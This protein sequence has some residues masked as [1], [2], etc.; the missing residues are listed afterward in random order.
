MAARMDAI[1]NVV[2][3]YEGDRPKLPALLLGS[4]YDTVCNAGKWEGPLGVVTAI[5]CVADLRRRGKRLPFAIEVIGFA[6][7]EGARFNSTLLGSRAVAGTFNEAVLSSR[8]RNGITMQ[9]ALQNF[10]LDPR[11]I[12][13]AARAGRVCRLSRT[14]H[15]AGS[16]AGG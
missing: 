15:R 13:D 16:D 9:E 5:A 12:G 3:R 11:H 4:H 14:T 8:D 7:E 2:G 10:G 6:D 1:G